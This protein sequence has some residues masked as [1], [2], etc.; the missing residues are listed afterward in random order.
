MCESPRNAFKK[1]KAVPSPDIVKFREVPFTALLS[2]ATTRCD[3]LTR[4]PRCAEHVIIV[5]TNIN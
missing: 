3:N 4:D 1:K 2:T 5:K